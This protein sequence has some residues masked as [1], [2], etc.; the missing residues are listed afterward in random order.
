MD[1]DVAAVAARVQLVVTYND[2]TVMYYPV[3]TSWRL[4]A[5]R[6]QLIIGSMPRTHI[7][8][9]QVRSFEVDNLPSTK[10]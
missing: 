5:A 8:L 2:D 6:R 3:K 9:D 10:E 7:P 1:T 4:D